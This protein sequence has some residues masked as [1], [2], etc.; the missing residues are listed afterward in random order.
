MIMEHRA[1]LRAAVSPANLVE[2]EKPGQHKA[3]KPQA[4]QAASA[5][6]KTQLKEDI[7]IELER[8]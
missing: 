4:G 7:K 5:L 2:K 1:Q 3:H 6:K 8:C